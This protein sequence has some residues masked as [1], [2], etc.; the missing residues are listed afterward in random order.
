M[1]SDRQPTEAAL[2][3]HIEEAEKVIAG[4]RELKQRLGATAMDRLDAIAR[5]E[6]KLAADGFKRAAKGV[7]H[8]ADAAKRRPELKPPPDAELY[9][10][11]LGPEFREGSWVSLDREPTI[12]SIQSDN[13]LEIEDRIIKL[14]PLQVY[15]FNRLLTNRYGLPTSFFAEKFRLADESQKQAHSRTHS[16]LKGFVWLLGEDIVSQSHIKHRPFSFGGYV[17]FIDKREG[18]VVADTEAEVSEVSTVTETNDDEPRQAPADPPVKVKKTVPAPPK[19]QP[20][21]RPV[22]QQNGVT[23]PQPHGALGPLVLQAAAGEAAALLRAGWRDA[24][25]IAAALAIE[26]DIVRAFV[27]RHRAKFG[28]VFPQTMQL[29]R[30]SW[31]MYTTRTTEHFPPAFAAWAIASIQRAKAEFEARQTQG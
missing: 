23:A 13:T 3:V 8:I 14:E 15:I 11:L 28:D 17:D 1:S 26:V 5:Y 29:R 30:P 2:D 31:E 24:H 22:A 6:L 9:V 19:P 4:L 21:T 7:Q 18:S 12:V 27:E 25:D 16:M 20:V 10:R